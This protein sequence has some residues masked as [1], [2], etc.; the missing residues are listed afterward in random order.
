MWNLE[1]TAWCAPV[2]GVA[3]SQ[4]QTTDGAIK[5]KDNFQYIF[6]LKSET[7]ETYYGVPKLKFQK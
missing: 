4:M 3:K 2:H 6:H 1:N 7:S 5:Q